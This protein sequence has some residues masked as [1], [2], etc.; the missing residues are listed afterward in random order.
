MNRKI[1]GTYLRPVKS[2]HF[3]RAVLERQQQEMTI[4]H[5]SNTMIG[6]GVYNPSFQ[7]HGWGWGRNKTVPPGDVLKFDRRLPWGV[8]LQQTPLSFWPCKLELDEEKPKHVGL[9]QQNGFVPAFLYSLLSFVQFAGARTR[10]SKAYYL[11]ENSAI[12]IIWVLLLLVFDWS[13]IMIGPS[14]FLLVIS[15][16]FA[17]P[18]LVL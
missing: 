6:P 14:S 12:T 4:S 3:T 5:W 9:A 7:V 17:I 10:H 13:I 1:L 18:V 11:P 15:H 8:L 16:L 2:A